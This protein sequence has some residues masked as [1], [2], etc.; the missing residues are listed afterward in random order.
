MPII[1]SLVLFVGG[2]QQAK[3]G[4]FSSDGFFSPPDGC[5][6]RHDPT[7]ELDRCGRNA[8]S[9]CVLAGA[10]QSVYYSR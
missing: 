10:K 5:S 7:L 6:G 9:S 1:P 3:G 2:A 4:S 8:V